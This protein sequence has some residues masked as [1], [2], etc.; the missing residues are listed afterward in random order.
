[1]LSNTKFN[2]KNNNRTE[3]R[4]QIEQNIT[5]FV[6]GT[7][8][9]KLLYVSILLITKSWSSFCVR[10][11]FF[12]NDTFSIK[13]ENI[14]IIIWVV[15]FGCLVD[16]LNRFNNFFKCFR[17]PSSSFL[18]L[19]CFISFVLRSSWEIYISCNKLIS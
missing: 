18:L 10:S 11:N 19:F 12:V 3:K 5:F 9:I 4:I 2:L 15:G 14:I 8:K 6:S 7:F 13:K 17:R 1:M 16:S